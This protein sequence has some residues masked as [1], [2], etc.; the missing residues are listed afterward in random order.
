MLSVTAACNCYS[1]GQH[2]DWG[3]GGDSHSQY[4][5]SEGWKHLD[6][7]Y[8]L[9]VCVWVDLGMN[10]LILSKARRARI[11]AHTSCHMCVMKCM[12]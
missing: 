7:Q 5:L 1:D 9:E 10:T 8:V 3:G 6:M 4:F 2:D 12:Q 11:S